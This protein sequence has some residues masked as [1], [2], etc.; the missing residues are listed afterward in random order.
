MKD[1]FSSLSL[2]GVPFQAVDLASLEE[3]QKYS[4]SLKMFRKGIDSL[5]EKKE[6]TKCPLFKQFLERHTVERTY[7]FQVFNCKTTECK[8]HK[9]LRGDEP[10][11]R[12]DPVPFIDDEGITH[13]KQGDDPEE[14]YIPSKLENLTKRNHGMDFS[15]SAKT[16]LNVG[17]LIKCSECKKPTLMHSKKSYPILKRGH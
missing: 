6:L 17:I 14:T 8:F 11:P 3:I 12:G 16:A 7:Y 13:Y 5:T 10:T 9:P 1:V 2:K 15:P 4:D